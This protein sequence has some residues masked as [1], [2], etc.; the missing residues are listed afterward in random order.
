MGKR[1][2]HSLEQITSKLREQGA[3]LKVSE[4]CREHTISEQTFFW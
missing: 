1:K 4:V 2:H 3:G